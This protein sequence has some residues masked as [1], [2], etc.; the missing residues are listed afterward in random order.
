VRNELLDQPTTAAADAGKYAKSGMLVI[1]YSSRQPTSPPLPA[2]AP[3]GPQAAA[4]ATEQPR[5]YRCHLH[6]AAAD[7]TAAAAAAN[8]GSAAAAAV[9]GSGGSTQWV[10]APSRGKQQLHDGQK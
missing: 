6:A 2:A 9:A 4:A 10:G 7:C 3:A 8:A 5:R 1:L